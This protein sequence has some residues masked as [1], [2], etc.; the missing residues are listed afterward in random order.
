MQYLLLDDGKA[1]GIFGDFF[2]FYLIIL[3]E[4]GSRKLANEVRL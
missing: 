3:F 1:A 4:E 2:F